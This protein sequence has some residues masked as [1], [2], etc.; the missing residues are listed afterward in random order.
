MLQL[1]SLL[2]V[3]D[4]IAT[5]ARTSCATAAAAATSAAAASW[6]AWWATAAARRAR[7]TRRITSW[8]RCIRTIAAIGISRIENLFQRIAKPVIWIPVVINRLAR[9]DLIGI[10]FKVAIGVIVASVRITGQIET[11][12]LRN[13]LSYVR[14]AGMSCLSRIISNNIIT[15][16]RIIIVIPW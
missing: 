16:I 4:L 10:H 15:A 6:W 11:S 1:F 2:H 5:S 8:W 3:Y 12:W 7:T 14:L 9:S 13:I